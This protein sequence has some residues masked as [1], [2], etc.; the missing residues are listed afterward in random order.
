MVTTEPRA[1]HGDLLSLKSQGAPHEAR[2]GPVPTIYMLSVVLGSCMHASN[3]VS[4]VLCD[5]YDS[6]IKNKFVYLFMVYTGH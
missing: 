3:A 1:K 2:P 6:S 4:G 5:K